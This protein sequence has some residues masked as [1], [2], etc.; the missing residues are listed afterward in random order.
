MRI[1]DGPMAVRFKILFLATLL[2]SCTRGPNLVEE[3]EFSHV[4]NQRFRTSQDLFLVNTGEYALR[5]PGSASYIPKTIAAYR[6]HPND[7]W[8]HEEGRPANYGKV[9]VI[10]VIPAGTEIEV[11]DVHLIRSG[12]CKGMYDPYGR[13]LLPEY[14]HHRVNLIGPFSHHTG[15]H[16]LDPDSD[17]LHVD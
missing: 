11:T 15:S 17:Y 13:I 4:A 3:P 2:I 1:I 9:Q 16:I 14:R 12:I 10:A 5:R 8:E 6:A 7:W